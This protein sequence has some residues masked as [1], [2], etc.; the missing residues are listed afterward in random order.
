MVRADHGGANPGNRSAAMVMPMPLLQINTPR[1]KF[2][3]SNS[4]A[5]IN[6]YS[7]N[8]PVGRVRAEI[9]K[10]I[11]APRQPVLQRRLDLDTAVVAR[12][13]NAQRTGVLVGRRAPPPRRRLA[14]GRRGLVDKHNQA[15][16]GIADLV[17]RAAVVQ[18]TD[19][20]GRQCPCSPPRSTLQTRARGTLSDAD[21]K[22]SGAR[23]DVDGSSRK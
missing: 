15:R 22:G 2:P 13:R 20:S 12:K 18:R 14:R 4:R 3:A 17:A 16:Q 21:G 5:T 1:S 19:R 8:P 23:P 9:R 7:G 6:A 11:S 10:R